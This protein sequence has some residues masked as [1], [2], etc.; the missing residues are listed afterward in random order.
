MPGIAKLHVHQVFS[1]RT[2]GRARP[3]RPAL[4]A[5]AAAGVLGL[6]AAGLAACSG[7]GGSSGNSPLE[8]SAAQSDVAIVPT[9]QG[10]TADD[11]FPIVSG[12]QVTPY[13]EQDFQWLMYRPLLWYGGQM[14][15]EFGLNTQTSLA[16]APVYSDGDKVVTVTLKHYD[17]SDGQPVT[18]RDITFFFDLLAANKDYYGEYT[19]GQ[20]PDNVKSL[21]IINPLTV[22]FTLTRAYSPEWFSTN[23]LS[24]ITPFPQ[25]AWDK[26]SA[27]GADGDYDQT[28]AGAVKVFNY[29]LSQA[30]A[31]NTYGS[32]PIWQV[33]D[34]PFRLESFST[35]GDIDLVPNKKYSGSPK[36]TIK[37]LI[38]RPYTSDTAQFNAL[39]SGSGLTYGFIPSQ[40]N[41]ELKA[42]ES[43]GY[44]SYISPVYGI[45]Y[46]V[47]NFN[48][49]AAGMLFRQLYIRQALQRLVNQPEDVK[50][51]YN[52]DAT[53]SYGPVPLAPPSPFT[54]SYERS[55]P[56]PFSTSA[57]ESLLRSHGW[58]VHPG[59][60]DTC[61]KPGTAADECGAGIA[62]GKAL[63]FRVVYASGDTDYSVMME[64]FQSAAHSAGVTVNLS[65]G[66][67]NEIT[68]ITGVCSTHQSACNWDGVMYGGTTYGVYPTGNDFFNTD[69]NGQGNYSSATADSLINATE[70]DAGADLFDQYENYIAQ[71][72]P[73]IWLPW[74]QPGYSVVLKNVKGF[75][76]DQDN[77]FT[78]TYPEN[79]SFSK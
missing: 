38:E 10:S 3:R 4:R 22:Q 9:T 69:A 49:P 74:Q 75:S 5:V 76:A 66:Q 28:H 36:P 21:K 34:G 35:R 18:A 8:T 64:N 24:D 71:Q 27:S 6:A 26:E 15:D 44:R 20:F 57:A 7:G 51:A 54:T 58:T 37:E 52:G 43:L 56:Y 31:L 50:Y 19:P 67:F 25:Q 13:N 40:D 53:P 78:D 29:L 42:V 73:F 16:S 65:E 62:A 12:P 55:N 45:N 48:S 68:G 77:A 63:S 47:I 1:P 79:W 46:I 17:W 32:N 41:K 11:I 72:L 59:G 33:V 2:T 61:A 30:R 39:I 23:E 70:Y 14:G 60:T